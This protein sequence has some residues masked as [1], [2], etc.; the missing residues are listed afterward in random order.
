M[1]ELNKLH[2]SNKVGS[3]GSR[4]IAGNSELFYETEKYIANFHNSESAL[5]FNSGYDANVGLLSSIPQ[6]GD[7][8]LYDELIHASIIDGI[9]LSFATHFK[10]K[11]NNLENLKL[12]FDRHKLLFKE[13]YVVV[14]SVYSMDGDCSPLKELVNITKLFDAH[15]IVDEAHAIGVFGKDGK[16]L[17]NELNIE[18][19]CFARIYTYGKALGCHGASVVGSEELKNYLINFARSFI[20]TTAM[21]EHNLLAI[22]AAYILLAKSNELE[23]LKSNI[24]Y[25]NQVIKSNQTFTESKGAIH[26]YLKSGN[27]NVQK[28]EEKLA[29]E[30]FFVKSI[31]SPTVKIN[32]ER[33]RICLHSFNSK[34]DIDKIVLMLTTQYCFLFSRFCC[35]FVLR[36]EGIKIKS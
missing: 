32:Q 14:E 34:D 16:G 27:E 18:K 22:K 19:D 1:D 3:T 24:E 33:I 23:K 8:V 15:L 11:H 20:Y 5:I 7:L 31:K 13:I 10:F 28:L 4:L 35:N 21:P 6:K 2:S 36:L 17:C 26:C 12:I 25:F 30:N 29:S 9:R